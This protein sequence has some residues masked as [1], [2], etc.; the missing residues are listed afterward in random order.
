MSH[1]EEFPNEYQN[2]E[3]VEQSPE[4]FA[5]QEEDRLAE[6]EE[7]RHVWAMTEHFH[8]EFAQPWSCNWY[9]K[10]LEEGIK[11]YLST[12]KCCGDCGGCEVE[13]WIEDEPEGL[14]PEGLH[15]SGTYMCRTVADL[16]EFDKVF[17]RL[18]FLKRISRQNGLVAMSA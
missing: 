14:R 17:D 5:Q 3:E 7:E 1:P 4:E 12:N 9:Y 6:E 18:I 10:L 11:C 2:E 8:E 13:I 16:Q 15:L